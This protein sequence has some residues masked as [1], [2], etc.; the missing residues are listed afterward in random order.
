MC[1]CVYRTRR[2]YKRRGALALIRY[3]GELQ[4]ILLNTCT[5]GEKWLNGFDRKKKCFL[6]CICF[7]T[8]F[9]RANANASQR[10]RGIGFFSI[11]ALLD[12]GYNNCEKFNSPRNFVTLHTNSIHVYLYTRVHAMRLEIWKL[13][14]FDSSKTA[15]VVR[16]QMIVFEQS[17]P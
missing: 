15:V 17:T 4:E 8:E 1:V 5:R 9:S 13:L 10:W 11:H 12:T 6:F 16:V 7:T 2:S 3:C 14:F